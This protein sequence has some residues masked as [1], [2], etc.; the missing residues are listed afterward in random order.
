LPPCNKIC[1]ALRKQCSEIDARQQHVAVG[2][3]LIQRVAQHV[4]KH[5][6][7]SFVE[8]R[9]QRGD[10]EWLPEFLNHIDI[11]LVLR[12]QFRNGGVTAISSGCG[13]GEGE[14][15]EAQLEHETHRIQSLSPRQSMRIEQPRQ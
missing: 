7:R 6:R 5:L 1:G 3:R 15:D 8:R 11:L 14:V 10:A 2:A 9:V 13:R 4:E 12:K